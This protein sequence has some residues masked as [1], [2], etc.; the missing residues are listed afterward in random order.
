VGKEREKRRRSYSVFPCF[1]F[2][3]AKIKKSSGI[4][5]PARLKLAG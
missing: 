4:Y 3:E 5:D 1:Y 2:V